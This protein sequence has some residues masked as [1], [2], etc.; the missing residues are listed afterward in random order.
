MVR[1]AFYDLDGTLVSGN[2]VQ[3]YAFFVRSLPSR[4]RA[5]VKGF[6][7]VMSVPIWIALDFWSRRLFNHVFYREYRGMRREWLCGLDEELFRRAVEPTIYP[8]AKALVEARLHVALPREAVSIAI[9]S[10]WARSQDQL[11]LH[12]DCVARNV[13]ATLADNRASFDG[14]WR[15]MAVPLNGRV[16]FA[17]RVDSADLADAAPL[18][19]MADGVEGARAHM[20]AYSLA[21][22]GATFDGK[23]GFVLLADQ[24]SLEGGGHA[25]DL[26]DHNCLIAHSTP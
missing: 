23:P 8:G 21:A 11:H 15:A 17:R 25:E 6:K 7:L 3:R 10:K 9:N 20:D 26:Q 12:V 4:A 19:L 5:A 2:I 14:V 13:A 16:Y 18:K 24:F 22:V 1:M